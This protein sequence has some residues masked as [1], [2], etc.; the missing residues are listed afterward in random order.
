ML[1]LFLVKKLPKLLI[2]LLLI[3]N[4]FLLGFLLAGCYSSSSTYSSVYLAKVQYNLS[5]D[6]YDNVKAAY[7]SQNSSTELSSMSLKIGYVGV[8]VDASN[9]TTCTSY[10]ELS[11]LSEYAGISIIPTTS[12]SKSRQIDLINIVQTFRDVC[13]ANVLIASIILTLL[14]LLIHFWTIIPLVPGKHLSRK[15]CCFLSAANVLLWG[16]G[17]MLQHEATKAAS[18]LLGPASMTVLSVTVG[19]RAE[20]MTWTAFTFLLI[21]CIGAIFTYIYELKREIREIE[22][23]F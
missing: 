16:L 10:G 9:K 23:K 21:I 8:C 13:Y 6:L 15:I 4:V 7:K 19:Q 22:P 2:L 18:K 20:A 11:S 3:I 5:S 12:K 17:A 14:L 1:I